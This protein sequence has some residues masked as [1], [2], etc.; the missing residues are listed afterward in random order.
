MWQHQCWRACLRAG[1]LYMS[2]LMGDCYPRW[3]A[4][5]K[6]GIKIKGLSSCGWLATGGSTMTGNGTRC[7]EQPIVSRNPALR[8]LPIRQRRVRDTCR[9]DEM[10]IHLNFQTL[11]VTPGISRGKVYDKLGE[12]GLPVMNATGAPAPTVY[13]RKFERFVLCL[14]YVRGR[15][16]GIS[17]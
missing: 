7:P 17:V 8:T 3:L 11:I 4:Q 2:D 1:Q 5:Y 12:C 9:F 13:T 16:K 10:K 6:M 15:R 14:L